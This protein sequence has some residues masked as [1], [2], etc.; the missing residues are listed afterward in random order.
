M[1]ESE[2]FL[3]YP[4]ESDHL[5]MTQEDLNEGERNSKKNVRTVLRT[6]VVIALAG[7]SIF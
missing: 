2:R 4:A 6:V 1:R 3:P 7:I 5:A